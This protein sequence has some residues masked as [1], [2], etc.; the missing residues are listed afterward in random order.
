[1]AC[2]LPLSYRLVLQTALADVFGTRADEFVVRVLF[3]DVAGP[4]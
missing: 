2:C 4:A 1:M 3:E